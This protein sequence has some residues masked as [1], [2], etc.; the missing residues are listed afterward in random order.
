MSFITPR[1]P[2]YLKRERIFV[3]SQLRDID[4]SRSSFDIVFR[5]PKRLHNIQAIE[6][7]DYNIPTDI[8]P[9]FIA[10]QQGLRGNNFLDVR[11]VNTDGQ[12]SIEFPVELETDRRYTTLTELADDLASQMDD[13]MDAQSHAYF[14]TGNMTFVN[15]STDAS[16]AKVDSYSWVVE[17]E[18]GQ[19]RFRVDDADTLTYFLFGSG[20]NKEDSASTVLGFDRR[21]TVIHG[22]NSTFNGFLMDTGPQSYHFA[23]I[24]PFR[25]IDVFIDRM[26]ESLR[27]APLARIPCTNNAYIKQTT[28]AKQPRILTTAIPRADEFRITLKLEGGYSPVA[29]TGTDGWDLVLD[30]ITVQEDVEVPDWLTQHMTLE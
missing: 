7:V 22:D 26:Q 5:L 16:E 6:L 25:Y 23:T 28:N 3:D 12:G 2:N 9:T 1:G 18:Y 10:A 13:A 20:P 30:V 21:D 24:R 14:N 27:G 29:A 17:G 19:L 4:S 8:S 11:L 15:V